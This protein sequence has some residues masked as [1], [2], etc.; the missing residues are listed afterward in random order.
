MKILARSQSALSASLFLHAMKPMPSPRVDD[1]GS[2]T[3]ESRDD[4]GIFPVL[5]HISAGTVF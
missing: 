5:R 4:K 1:L 3:E 2:G